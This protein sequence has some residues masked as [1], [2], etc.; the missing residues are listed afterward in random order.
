MPKLDPRCTAWLSI[1]LLI[2][3]AG[4][5]AAQPAAFRSHAPTRPLA[6]P[7][8]RPLA[9]GPALFVDAAKG[10]DAHDGTRERPWRTVAHAAA[11]LKP[12]DTLYL[13]G[14]TYFEH[15]MVSSSGTLQK[16]VT[17]R[18]YPGELAVIDGGLREFYEEP[19]TAWEPCPGGVE[20]EFRSV[21]TYP[22]LGGTPKGCNVL[23]RFGDSLVPLQGYRFLADLRDPSMVWDLKDK[24]GDEGSVYCG[25]GIYYDLETGRIHARLA[26]TSIRALGDD[27]YR[28][29][30]DPRKLPLV[31]AGLKAGPALTIRGA[32]HLRLQDLVVRG[33][34]TAAIEIADCRDV[35]CN[36][37]TV[38][39]GGS[40]FAV[41]GTTGLRLYHTACRGI[42]APWTFRGHLKYRSTEA[43]IFSASGWSPTGNDNRDFDIAYSEFTDS[44]DG[45]FI[46]NVQHV[47]FRHNLLD[48]V[49]DD[50]IF[51][52]STTAYD[53]TTPGGQVYVYQNVL[54][55]CLT[56]FAFG[57]GHGRQKA[58]AA[59][60]QTGSGVHVFRNIFDYRRPVMYHFPPDPAGDEELPSK[61][62][63]ASDHGGPTWEPMHLYH[64]TIIADDR[65]GYFYG[66]AGLGDHIGA[67][68]RRRVFNNIVLQVGGLPGTFF[69]PTTSDLQTD[70]NL[71]WSAGQG[72]SFRGDL[73]AKFRSSKDSQASKAR[74]S[75]G[76]GAS[77]RFMDPRFGA[78]R[79]DWKQP[80]DLSLQSDSPAINAGVTVAAEWPDPLRAADEGK[81]DVG[82]LPLGGKPWQVGVRGRLTMFGE[83]KVASTSPTIARVVFPERPAQRAVIS[84][85]AKPA[86]I[87]QGYPAFDVPLVEFALKR[88]GL[89]VNTLERTWLVPNDY[90][91]YGL[92]VIAGNL[93]RAKI[94]P[95]KYSAADL[96]RVR[97]YLEQGGTLILMRGTTE[98]FATPH[99]RR[100]L[101]ELTGASPTGGEVK[102]EVLQPKH[103]W[104]KH[105]KP[106]LTE[107]KLPVPPDPLSDRKQPGSLDDLLDRKQA[108]AKPAASIA[109]AV[110]YLDPRRTVPLWASKG[111]RIIGARD[112]GATTLYRLRVGKGQLIYLGWELHDSL[113]TSQS[114]P[115]QEQL[116]EDQMQVLFQIV[117]EVYPAAEGKPR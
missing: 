111:E 32:S 16:P 53:G 38:Y 47:H 117:W 88:R 27:N 49:S 20:G 26:H 94:E 69:P 14:G 58:T 3:A 93:V 9:D 99:G 106:A 6:A 57:V 68:T 33:A 43:R 107:S 36:G 110:S 52:T 82:A 96:D 24:V 12:G 5:V 70:G 48:N 83:E 89:T 101:A 102:L 64:N 116:F 80:M 81:P 77:D 11:R 61:G 98:V 71:F 115:P 100:F 76:W 90:G 113:P 87:V 41:R 104:A 46:G 28:G 56:T 55:R 109:L 29:E 95:N 22:N 66:T 114:K 35:E 17:I 91:Q 75:P 23:G 40:C 39:G 86:V 42:A 13:R 73:F 44:V 30:T 72:P 112:S 103:A 21:K 1:W 4:G 97:S 74:Y 15:A 51:L 79:A 63:V 54:A 10:D 59:G 50:G 25:P 62:R 34:R 45:V 78:F 85:E 37:L 108:K 84:G 65:G 60:R 92:V 18:S 2:P 19:A 7:S 67:G 31:I 105:L 8:D